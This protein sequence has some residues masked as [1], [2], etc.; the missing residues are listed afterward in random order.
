VRMPVEEPAFVSSRCSRSTQRLRDPRPGEERTV[1]A[2]EG[3]PTERRAPPTSASRRTA[4]NSQRT[5]SQARGTSAAAALLRK[6]DPGTRACRTRVQSA[7]MKRNAVAGAARNERTVEP[8]DHPWRA[9]Q[10]W[11]APP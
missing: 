11:L 5:P 6:T 3:E 1:Q 8:T 7:G 4:A 2:A 10:P 9:H